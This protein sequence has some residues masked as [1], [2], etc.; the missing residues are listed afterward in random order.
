M[1]HPRSTLLTLWL[2]ALLLAAAATPAVRA[3]DVPRWQVYET[4]LTSSGTYTTTTAYTTLTVTANFTDP[5]GVPHAVQG[6]LYGSDNPQGSGHV[7]YRIRYN[8]NIR[9][10][11]TYTVA[12]SNG[13]SGLTVSTPVSLRCIATAPPPGGFVPHGFLRRDPGFLYSFVWDDGARPF[14]WG[15]TYYQVVNQARGQVGQCPTNPVPDPDTCPWRIAVKNSAGFGMNKVRMVVSPW[16]KDPRYVETQPFPRVGGVLNHNDLD[17]VHWQSLDT[18]VQYLNTQ[19]IAAEIILF[20]DPLLRPGVQ[21]PCSPPTCESFFGDLTQ[22]QR[23]VRYAIARYAAYPNVIWSLTNEWQCTLQ[24]K[25]YWNDMGCLIRGGC[26]GYGASADPWFSD[27]TKLRPLSIHPQPALCYGFFGEPWPVHAVLQHT[28]VGKGDQWGYNSIACNRRSD[29]NSCPPVTGKDQIPIV[30]DEYGYLGK[31]ANQDTHRNAIWGI[32]AGGGFGSAGD[33]RATCLPGCNC[34]DPA[35]IVAPIQ[36]TQ[37]ADTLAPPATNG[38]EYAD[39]QRLSSF[40]V[41][42]AIPFWNM[43]PQTACQDAGRVYVLAE[44]A[45]VPTRQYVIYDAIGGTVTVAVG[46]GTYAQVWLNPRTGVTTVKPNL[47]VTTG[48]ASFAFGGFNDWVAW[49]KKIG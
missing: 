24:P 2:F 25:S 32:A 11:W 1:N 17:L 28:N 8:M 35:C 37:W 16:T 4:S 3:V 45:T 22:D 29:A 40:F 34:G 20:R 33:A 46:N 30:N 15:Q 12:A 19:D 41:N 42:N 9:G 10:P 18:A 21:C 13:D 49:L 7:T 31:L 47:V 44:P 43:A 26:G 48:S 27:T 14:L 39:L 5:N 6:F 38:G 36:S 23:Y